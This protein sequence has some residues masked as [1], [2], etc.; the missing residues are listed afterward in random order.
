MIYYINLTKMRKVHYMI[1]KK[2]KKNKEQIFF[3]HKFK[4]KFS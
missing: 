3:L 2:N 1:Y 4:E